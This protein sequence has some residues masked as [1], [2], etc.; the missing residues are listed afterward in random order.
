[1]YYVYDEAGH[2]LGEYASNGNPNQ[3]TIWLGDIPVLTFRTSTQERIAD[4]NSTATTARATVTGT[5]ATATTIKGYFGANY[6]SHVV[7][8]STTDNVTYTI[9]PTATQ[10]FNVYARWVAQASNA[11]NATYTIAPN[12]A[13]STPLVVTVNQRQDGGTWNYLGTVNLNTANQMT[14]TLS[15]QG[16][17]MVM[18]DAVKIVP[19]TTS[20][21]QASAFNIYTDHLNTPREIRNHAN[22]L[23]WTWYPEVS[24]AFGAGL[25]NEN[26][27][28]PALGVFTYNL[29]F[30]GQLYDPTSQLSYNYY[31]DYSSR[32]GRYIESDPIGL[33]GGI[34]TYGYVGGNP[35]SY[36]DPRGLEATMDWGTRLGTAGAA[37]ASDG[38]IP[39]GDIIGL[40][41]IAKGIYD[42]CTAKDCPPCKTVSGRIVP[43]GTIAYR[44]MDTPKKPQH[45]IDGPHYNISKANQIPSPNCDCFWQ[46]LGAVRPS[47]LPATAIPIEDFMN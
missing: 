9:T 16:N 8:A 11:S 5:W 4:N 29:R 20:A 24:G 38:P 28:T 39:I 36:V 30:P 26:P 44:P 23:R 14:V 32:T 10:S 22:Q 25:P 46:P 27:N 15:G 37:A 18:A 42:V 21:T 43:V 2:L 13:G 17:G 7:A 41:I 31:R 19:N 47:E 12:T 34:N 3:E 40:G 6:R 45:G 35:L 1:V 33:E